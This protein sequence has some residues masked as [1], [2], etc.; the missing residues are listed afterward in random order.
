MKKGC[1]IAAVVV[2]VL[3][4]L[5]VGGCLWFVGTKGTKFANAGAAFA[6]E[7]AISEYQRQNP[8]AQVAP[9]NEAWAEALQGFSGTADLSQFVK[10]GKIVDV[11][12]NEMQI[13][14]DPDG[15]VRVTSPGK[16]GQI[17]TEDDVDSGM[18]EALQQ[19]VEE[20]TEQQPQ[21]PQ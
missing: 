13:S 15:T 4:A 3:G 7:M 6:V 1:I 10:N 18:F 12:Q 20:A 14:Q 17:G 8:D 21:Q 16:D 2:L 19:K 11:F 5:I 9:T